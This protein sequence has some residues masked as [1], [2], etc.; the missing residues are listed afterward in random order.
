[1]P[2]GFRTDV[3]RGWDWDAVNAS[4]QRFALRRIGEPEEIVGTVLYLASDAS[5]FTTGA[6]FPVDG[7]VPT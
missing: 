5:S 1:M 6:V 4:A 3:T 2:G 7:G